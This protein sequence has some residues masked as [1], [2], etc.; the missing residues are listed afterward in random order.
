[1]SFIKPNAPVVE[2]SLN[3]C[4]DF[5]IY[6]QLG[7]PPDSGLPFM[8]RGRMLRL[9]SGAKTDWLSSAKF[10][11][12]Y[13]QDTN[14]AYPA[15]AH[16]GFYRGYIDESLDG[17]KTWTPWKLSQYNKDDADSAL[18]ELCL[19]NMVDPDKAR[20][21]YLAVHEF[22]KAAWDDDEASRRANSPA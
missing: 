11:K 2:S 12:L 15:G 22:G 7:E 20:M 6:H 9:R 16:D 3:Q 21:I 19:D 14:T 4:D 10:A 18:W 5:T 13:I 8:W 17:G 1:M